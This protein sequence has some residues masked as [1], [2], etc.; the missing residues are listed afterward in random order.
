MTEQIS[1]EEHLD[2][3]RRVQS[4]DC[5]R[6]Q[7]PKGRPCV[8]PSGQPTEPH[9]AARYAKLYRRKAGRA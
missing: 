1:V 7:A 8:G 2:R 5:P 9:H 4:V 3:I 6:C